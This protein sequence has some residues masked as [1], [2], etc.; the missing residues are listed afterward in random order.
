M[1]DKDILYYYDY[2]LRLAMS[3][4]NSQADAQ[5][6]VGDTMLAAFSCMHKGGEIKYPKTW[7]TNTLYNKYNDELRK[8]YRSPEIV[9]IDE[10]VNIANEESD[11]YFSTEEAA[12]V[13]KELNHLAYITREVLIRRYYGNQSI[14]DITSGLSIPAGTVKSR[15][16]TGRSQM[17]KGLENMEIRENYLPG[18]L[19]L[20]FGGAAGITGEPMSLVESDLIAQNLLILA[21][22]KPATISELSKMIAIPAVY[23]EPI[24]EKLVN[25]ELMVQT[26]GGKYYTDFIIRKPDNAIESFESQLNFGHRHFD[27]IWKVI[28]EL[29]EKIYDL[30]FVKKMTSHQKMKLNRYAILKSLQDFQHLG[31]NIFSIPKYPLRRDGGHWFAQGYAI[32]AGYNEKELNKTNEYIIY[33]GHRST[34]YVPLEGRINE[35]LFYEFDTMLLDYPYRHS[36]VSQENYFKFIQ[37]LLWSI[38]EK[39]PLEDT[40]VP[41]DMIEAIPKFEEVGLI[42]SVDGNIKVD[43]PVLSKSEYDEILSLMK[44]A[45]EELKNV[46]ITE[47][48]ALIKGNKTMIPKHLLS[49]PELFRYIDATQYIV[50]AIVREAYERELHMKDVDYCCPPVVL[51]YV[52]KNT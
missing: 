24:L 10:G 27:V 51:V 35:L 39:T 21:Y 48:E 4:C 20:A 25:G 30:N 19:Y 32:S 12:K 47:Y 28:S 5:D 2:L 11:D 8:K 3:K 16:S 36:I 7:L 50:M 37:L 29:S 40:E 43:I 18:K 49:V 22:D 14:S 1:R 23:I 26:D 46:L 9:C 31:T 41:N 17:R 6:L 33:G 45:T 34:R 52:E 13:R 44:N 15:L 42:S 38:Y